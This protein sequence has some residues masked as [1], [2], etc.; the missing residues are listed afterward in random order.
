MEG[1]DITGG[2]E[3]GNGAPRVEPAPQLCAEPLIRLAY[4]AM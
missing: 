3:D 1:H 2:R 4:L